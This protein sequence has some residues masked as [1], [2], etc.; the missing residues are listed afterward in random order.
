M[1]QTEEGNK[2]KLFISVF[3]ISLL[4]PITLILQAQ[5]ISDPIEVIENRITDKVSVYNISG[6]QSTNVIVINTDEG[7]IVIDSETSP[8][9]AKSIRDRIEKANNGEK[10]SYLINTHDHGDHTYG[11]QVF[12]DATIIGHEKCKHEMINNKDKVEKTRTQIT[13]VLTAMNERMK[14]LDKQSDAA[15]RLTNIISYYEPLAKGLGEDFVLTTPT[16]IFTDKYQLKLGSETLTLIYYGYSHSYSDIIISYPKEK[17]LITGDLFAEG[18]V[19]YFDS[20]RIQYMDKW[21][22]TL[23]SVLTDTNE[24]KYIIPG[25]GKLLPV[26]LLV[27]NYKI[28]KEKLNEFKGKES[29]YYKFIK[30]YENDGLIASTEKMRELKADNSHYYFLHPEFDTYV[31]KLMMNDKLSD[32]LELFTVLAELFPDSYIAFDSLGEICLKKGDI[33]N[34]KKYFSKSLEL[35]PQNENASEKLNELN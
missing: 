35:N 29:A 26:S 6:L 31:Y 14:K 2:V 18:D 34:A 13:N 28:I 17:I 32:A 12:A 3:I 21:I 7:L 19:P 20:D 30:S 1:I 23:G 5:A 27:N 8:A 15:K 22:E 4:L 33:A 24:I 9:F 11:N 10:I 16:K 25:H